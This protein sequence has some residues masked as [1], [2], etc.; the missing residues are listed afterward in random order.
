VHSINIIFRILFIVWSLIFTCDHN[1]WAW[2]HIHSFIR[3][4]EREREKEGEREREI[5]GDTAEL[6]EK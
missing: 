6:V 4:R 2:L 3:Q 1:P 5:F